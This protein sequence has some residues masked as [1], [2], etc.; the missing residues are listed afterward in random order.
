MDELPNLSIVVME[1]LCEGNGI[2]LL[3]SVGEGINRIVG[4]E[5]AIGM[6]IILENADHVPDLLCIDDQLVLFHV[7]HTSANI[8]V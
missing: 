6:A 7:Q 5:L 2:E 3:R 4:I 1:F 8:M